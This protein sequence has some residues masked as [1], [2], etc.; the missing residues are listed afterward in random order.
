MIEYWLNILLY[1]IPI[2]ALYFLPKEKKISLKA[3][4]VWRIFNRQKFRKYKDNLD[5][6]FNA[7][8]QKLVLERLKEEQT[9]KAKTENKKPLTYFIKSHPD[10]DVNFKFSFVSFFL[11][12]GAILIQAEVGINI[13]STVIGGTAALFF[14]YSTPVAIIQFIGILHKWR[15]QV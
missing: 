7:A 5:K 10:I 15:S 6:E 9:F 4:I 3:N 1:L 2:T 12:F 14:L 8:V 13:F 11:A